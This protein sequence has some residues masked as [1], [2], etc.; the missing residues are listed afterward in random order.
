[1][2]TN[3]PVFYDFCVG[4]PSRGLLRDCTTST[5]NRFIA[6]TTPCHVTGISAVI[7]AGRGSVT[8]T[9]RRSGRA[10]TVTTTAAPSTS[11]SGTGRAPSSLPQQQYYS[12]NKH[13]RIDI[14]VYVMHHQDC[15]IYW[16]QNKNSN[17]FVLRIRH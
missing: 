2:L 3:P 9:R 12:E 1:M 10:P 5:I 16:L 15:S 4:V 7:G 8:M 11:R 14:K 6:L 13:R 17:I